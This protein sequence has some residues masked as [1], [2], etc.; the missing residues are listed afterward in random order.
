M[1]LR[2]A[3]SLSYVEKYGSYVIGLGSTMVISRL[4]QPSD[5]GVFAVG[6]ALVGII[7]VV[8]ELGVGTYIVQE[9]DLSPQRVRAAFWLAV[10]MGAALSMLV[11][12][13]SLPAGYFYRD[14]RV[15]SVVVVLGLSFAL[16]PLGSV[17]QALLSRELRFGALAWIRLLNA[18][19]LALVSIALALSGFGP[20]SLAW[21]MVAASV[22]NAVV[23]FTARPHPCRPN[24]DRGALAR[25]LAVG[26]PATVIA[27]VDDIV[28]SIPELVLG[29]VQGL[30]PAGLLSRARGLSQMP[31]QLLA[32]AAG[33]VFFAAF[34]ARRREGI[35][36]TPLYLK[37]SA[38]VTTLGWALLAAM[39]V[40]AP[41]IVLVIFGSHWMAVAPL[42]RWLCLAAALGLLTSGA[43]H[44]LLASGGTKDV[45]WAK[46]ASVPA[47]LVCLIV[48]AYFGAEGLA[49]GV[50]F[51][52]AAAGILMSLAV[53]RRSGIGLRA[54]LGP[55]WLS[56]PIVS[57][58]I[59]GCIPG[60]FLDATHLGQALANLALSG[61]G[62]TILATAAL[63]R[64]NHPLREE[65]RNVWAQVQGRR[66]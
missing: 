23:S 15:T 30:A 55:A 16:T 38:C 64:S 17:S 7:A 12:G 35:D 61:A 47:H 29:R 18:A 6:M 26:G 1:A 65:L 9:D 27:I 10:L 2:R 31:H 5:I 48:G 62:C 58:A 50:V 8:R 66:K 49:I 53:K 41:P 57:A 19:V 32:R 45:M 39:A 60:L 54:Q 51:S 14:P 59:V 4:L 44:F 37:A 34:S 20:M 21:A 22:V 28:S 36:I 25:V 52:T 11:L 24:L 42:L 3:L 40:L 63:M 56:L 13:A 43:H 46:I 33:P